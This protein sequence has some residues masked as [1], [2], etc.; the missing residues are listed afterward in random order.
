MLV[1]LLLLECLLLR[2]RDLLGLDPAVPLLLVPQMLPGGIARRVEPGHDAVVSQCLLME[3]FFG[4]PGRQLHLGVRLI[5]RPGAAVEILL[6]DRLMGRVILD[7][8]ADDFGSIP[9]PLIGDQAHQTPCQ[10]IAT[11]RTGPPAT[12]A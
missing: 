9:F 4:A 1:R 2:G 3:P 6:D 11:G 8:L 7:L 12:D 5:G 10:R